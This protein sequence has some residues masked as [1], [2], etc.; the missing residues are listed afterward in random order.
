M[1]F[2]VYLT[3]LVVSIST[4]LLEVHW[5]ASP[6]PRLNPTVQTRATQP[7]KTEGSHAGVRTVYPDASR[8]LE[9]DSQVQTTDTP[10]ASAS[11]QSL[12]A[13]PVPPQQP[14]AAPQPSA[15]QSRTETTG[16]AVR[17]ENTR[18]SSNG[19]DNSQQQPATLG[20]SGNRCDILACASTY[21]SFRA[22]D[23][24]YQPFD[25]GT[26]RL[27]EKSVGQR[28]V[29]E[30]E[31]PNRGRGRRDAEVHNADR[32]TNADDDAVDVDDFIRQPS[33]FLD[34]IFLGRRP[35]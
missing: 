12:P 13:T 11:Q 4:L 10:Q 2:L 5:L 20:S 27:C 9:T 8:P 17:E 1:Q 14:L 32:A 7:A 21:R 22:N 15:Q 31:Q 3:L 6:E 33:G 19:A 24:T 26:R 35:R 25:G 30:R 16:A 28:I 18:N 23:C 29:R 34:F